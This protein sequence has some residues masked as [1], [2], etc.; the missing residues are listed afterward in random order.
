MFGVFEIW[1]L[2]FVSLLL[3]ELG[4]KRIIV[5]A[6]QSWDD[7]FDAPGVSSDFIMSGC[8]RMR[9]KNLKPRNWS[10]AVAR[11]VR[12]RVFERVV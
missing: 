8:S 10:Y 2:E 3:L 6:G 1:K 5:S 11:R 7:W 9:W 4:N 12:E